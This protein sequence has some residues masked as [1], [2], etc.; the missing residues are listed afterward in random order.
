MILLMLRQRSKLK[1]EEQYLYW[2]ERRTRT[3]FRAKRANGPDMPVP[4]LRAHIS[5][6]KLKVIP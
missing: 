2:K 3:S 6:L 5:Y 1:F 4:R